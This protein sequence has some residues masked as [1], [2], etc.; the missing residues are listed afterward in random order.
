M[1]R[2]NF[3]DMYRMPEQTTEGASPY[4]MLGM[5][6]GDS[7]AGYQAQPEPQQTMQAD[8]QAVQ[9]MMN[10]MVPT[11][12]TQSVSTKQSGPSMDPND[13]FLKGLQD[14][15]KEREGSIK[16]MK[17]QLMGYYD[18]PYNTQNQL[19]LS[20]LAG[21][22]DAQTHSNFRS[23]YQKPQDHRQETID[24]LRTAISTQSKDVADDQLA[25]L[26]Q[27]ATS[28]NDELD[29][30]MKMQMLQQALDGRK[31]IKAMGSSARMIPASAS[32]QLGD[33]TNQHAAADTILDEWKKSMGG[34]DS[35][36]GYVSQNLKS[37]NPN[38][39]QNI[40]Q[41]KL[42]QY[43]QMIGTA[44]EG[45]KLTDNDYSKYMKFLPQVGDSAEAANAK[46]QN[47][48]Q[49]IQSKHNS[50]LASY[51]QTGYS[52]GSIPQIT[53]QRAP[54]PP[55]SGISAEDQAALMWAKQNANDPRA[56]AILQM[57]GAQ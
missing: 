16:G 44:L 37:M 33:L 17:T 5:L 36:G 43:A 23:Y 50:L 56:A 32:A 54:P 52:T 40:Y 20:P 39:T 19:D 53:D 35:L 38:S 25:Y 34:V 1:P 46:I 13:M 22:V 7:L 48:K 42:K 55:S 18:A 29:R 24:K 3:V 11:Q 31:Q 9:Q 45:G 47:L 41:S 14:N 2:K 28:K 57:H 30:N 10:Q 26:K 27:M 4:A 8:P 51:D 15:I 21:F 12:M 6:G 49:M